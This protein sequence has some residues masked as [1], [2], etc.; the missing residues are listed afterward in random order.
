MYAYDWG[1]LLKYDLEPDSLTLQKSANLPF[2]VDELK[3]NEDDHS[4]YLKAGYHDIY[5]IYNRIVKLNAND[6]SV[7]EEIYIPSQ[8]TGMLNAYCVRGQYLYFSA[9]DN[10]SWST[11]PRVYEYDLV[12]KKLVRSWATTSLVGSM[13][14]SPDLKT[15]YL[16]EDG[17]FNRTSYIKLRRTENEKF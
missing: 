10:Y 2:Y 9:N 4:L 12:N 15:L 13:E 8:N 1:K 11:N 5:T 16:T 7:E 14:V 3:M 6:F 17:S